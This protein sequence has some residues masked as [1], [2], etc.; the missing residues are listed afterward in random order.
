MKTDWTAAV[1]VRVGQD[2]AIAIRFP[3]PCLDDFLM[4]AALG[5]DWTRM[6]R[7]G[8]RSATMDDGAF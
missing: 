6:I 7:N 4:A 3:K 5:M 2:R 1:A 8:D